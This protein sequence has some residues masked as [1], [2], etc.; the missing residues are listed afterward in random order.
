MGMRRC[1]PAWPWAEAP[2]VH[3]ASGRRAAAACVRARSLGRPAPHG[4]SWTHMRIRDANDGL[5]PRRFDVEAE[6]QI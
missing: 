4:Q 1:V 3:S 2:R 6:S 5:R